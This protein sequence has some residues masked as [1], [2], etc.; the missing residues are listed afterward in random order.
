M[1]RKALETKSG[2][3]LAAN[4]RLLP[5]TAPHTAWETDKPSINKHQAHTHQLK[6]P[7]NQ[8]QQRQRPQSAPAGAKPSQPTA[9]NCCQRQPHTAWETNHQSNQQ[10]HPGTHTNQKSPRNQQQQRH[11]R[12]SRRPQSAPAGATVAANRQK[13]LPKTAP[14]CVGDKPSIN[15]HQATFPPLCAA[16]PRCPSTQETPQVTHA[17]LPLSCVPTCLLL[18]LWVNKPLEQQPFL[19][20]AATLGGSASAAAAAA[21]AR[22][23]AAATTTT[24]TTGPSTTPQPRKEKAGRQA[25][26]GSNNSSS[27]SS[28]PSP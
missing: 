15:K 14:H 18:L 23:A 24:T 3:T 5:K 28:R 1:P 4:R 22:A 11:R 6:S 12:A 16:P 10:A 19:S 9:K 2:A 27:S 21:R 7:R 26:K 17:W 20:F 25:S 8:Q 13:L